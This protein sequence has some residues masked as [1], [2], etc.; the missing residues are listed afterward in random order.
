[1]KKNILSILIVFTLISE[2]LLST[3]A[4]ISTI[5]NTVATG[6]TANIAVTAINFNNIGS[7]NLKL[8]YNPAFFSVSS[9]TLGPLLGGSLSVN[10][11]VPGT[12]VL[13][14]YTYPG[15]TVGIRS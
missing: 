3:N 11:T 9:V 4:P 1:M 5:P 14:W 6:S 7:F 15:I 13:G 10:L 8:L 2:T 12:I